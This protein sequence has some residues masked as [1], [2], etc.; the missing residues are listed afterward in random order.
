MEN[1]EKILMFLKQINPKKFKLQ[2][3]TLVDA[4]NHCDLD[5][6]SINRLFEILDLMYKIESY[7]QK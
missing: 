6:T 1:D 3:H 7:L 2:R 4:M 5:K